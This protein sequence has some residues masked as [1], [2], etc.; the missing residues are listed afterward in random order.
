MPAVVLPGCR[1][2]PVATAAYCSFGA[3]AAFRQVPAHFA[4]SISHPDDHSIV[5]ETNS[6]PILYCTL[7]WQNVS[8]TL[9][10]CMIFSLLT[11]YR[12][13]AIFLSVFH[14]MFTIEMK[15]FVS[16]RLSALIPP[17]YLF[18]PAGTCQQRC[19]QGPSTKY[20]KTAL[21]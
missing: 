9:K 1:S 10:S 11:K 8:Y 13:M 18:A 2:C 7:F 16:L 20:R 4:G 21:F 6:P 15:Y 14:R 5:G 17:M 3:L 19:L 12:K